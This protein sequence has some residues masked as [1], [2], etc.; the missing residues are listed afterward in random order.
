MVPSAAALGAVVVHCWNPAHERVDRTRRGGRSLTHR[1]GQPST[2]DRAWRREPCTA[3]RARSEEGARS[4]EQFGDRGSMGSP[5]E[6]PAHLS[7]AVVVLL[8]HH[9]CQDLEAAKSLARAGPYYD[10]T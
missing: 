2:G 10:P 6:C 8:V 9:A 3:G 7:A 1:R 5:R 4:D